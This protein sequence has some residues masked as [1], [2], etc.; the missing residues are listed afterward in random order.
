MKRTVEMQQNSYEL[1]TRHPFYGRI[2][3]IMNWEEPFASNRFVSYNDWF[4]C[5][6]ITIST[7]LEHL[8]L[9]ISLNLSQWKYCIENEFA[10]GWALGSYLRKWNGNQMPNSIKSVWNMMIRKPTRKA[11]QMPK[12]L[13]NEFCASFNR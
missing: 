13:F 8:Y 10:F 6:T 3:K 7:V 1:L 2:G 5:H 11:T 4:G 9:S 12:N